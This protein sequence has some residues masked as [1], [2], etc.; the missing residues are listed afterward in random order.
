MSVN[1]LIYRNFK[2][3]LPHYALYIFALA[4]S[5]ALYFAFVT[6]QYAPSLNEVKSSVKGLA[7]FRSA[8]ILLVV[9]VA[10]FLLYA[11]HLFIKRRSKEI[12]LF[13]LVGMM[14][15]E[16]FWIFSVE[17]FLLYFG[18]L[19][20]GIF[21]GFAASKL[22]LMI[23][24]KI[25][26]INIS[27]ALNF[28]PK[29]FVQILF[30]FTLIFILVLLMNYIFI[31]RQSILGL[32]Q[33]VTATE[34][35]SGN[36]SGFEIFSGILGFVC[37]AAGYFISSK[38]FDGDITT[39]NA[40]FTAMAS[41]LALV[42]FGTYLFYKTSVRFVFHLIRKKKD[43]YLNIN[44]VMSLS[45]IMF[46]MRSNAVLLTIITT[47]SALAIGLLSL[48]YIT[49]YSAEKAARNA[50]AADFSFTNAKDA[51]QFAQKLRTNKIPFRKKEIAVVQE[52]ADL[53][54]LFQ[55]DTKDLNLNP[56]SVQ[57]SVISDRS[58]IGLDV[59]PGQAVL[60]GYVDALAKFMPMKSSGNFELTGK[61][62]TATLRC[63]ALRKERLLSSY[64]S[65]GG[66][67]AVVVDDAL[68]RGLQKDADP[69]IQRSSSL[70]ISV[71][72]SRNQDLEKAGRLFRNIRFNRNDSSYSSPAMIK[73]QK[74]NMGIVMFIIGFLGLTFLVTSGCI[75]YFKQMEESEEEKPTYTI[76]RKLGFTDHDLAKGIRI[77]QLFNF[78]I[79]LLLGLLHSYF[80]V[81]SGWFFFGSELWA[82]MLIVMGLYTL[83]YSVFALL[84]V[85]GYK[86]AI[87]DAL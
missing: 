55:V 62:K 58:V 13:Q 35:K 70:F 38:L 68:F 7:A 37:I 45:T 25:L 34:D 60:S 30:V 21:F 22:L 2:K 36:I 23:L 31:K 54:S 27:V 33:A 65:N 56:K 61:Q 50:A 81:Q 78:G 14:K 84:S 8:S 41:I 57:V 29:A 11:N 86:K 85:E 40:L 73:Q 44:E 79:P 76:L 46:R 49:Y 1:G 12:G 6:L 15:K 74:E 64:F 10:I 24:F 82:P 69:K 72:L 83:L 47:V 71:N 66:M 19:L 53:S 67:P 18:S 9:I 4:F 20:I 52:K 42:I 48:S 77:K 43:G 5:A 26:N 39:V 59:K 51:E 63:V 17:N 75:L 28:S 80:A 87:R 3:N 32:F 16:I